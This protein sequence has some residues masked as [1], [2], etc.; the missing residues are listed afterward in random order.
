MESLEQT[1][2][3]AK[4]TLY[5]RLA[6]YEGMAKFNGGPE[7]R[8]PQ[9]DVVVETR[10]DFLES[11]AYLCDIEKG[12]ATVT[13]T[14]LQRLSYCNILWLSANEGLHRQVKAYAE[15][16]RQKLVAM[17]PENQSTLQEEIFRRA[18]QMCTP[19]LLFYKAE[20]QKYATRCRMALR[21]EL[22]Q[23]LNNDGT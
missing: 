14:G 17:T 10:R 4:K 18:V 2:Q 8:R 6:L 16:L 5:P 3:D 11:F 22:W 9:G 15:V 19:R 13:A 21:E 20:V 12:G 7:R 1:I 23:N